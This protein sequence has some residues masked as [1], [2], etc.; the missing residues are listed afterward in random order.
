MGTH[1]TRSS[2]PTDSLQSNPSFLTIMNLPA[3][4]L[5][6]ATVLVA[7]FQQTPAAEVVEDPMSEVQLEVHGVG[8]EMDMKMEKHEEGYTSSVTAAPEVPAPVAPEV[9]ENR[10]LGYKYNT[11][12]KHRGESCLEIRS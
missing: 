9:T 11:P 12:L 8:K 1:L 3:T 5:L 4:V 7:V 10:V 6:L 2:K